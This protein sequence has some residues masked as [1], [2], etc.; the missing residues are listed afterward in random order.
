MDPIE[1]ILASSVGIK[2]ILYEKSPGVCLEPLNFLGVSD[3]ARV[4]S[5]YKLEILPDNRILGKRLASSGCIEFL[6]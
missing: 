6:S 5:T 3:Q 4:R 1:T 2:S